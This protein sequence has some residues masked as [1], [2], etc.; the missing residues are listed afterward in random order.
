MK[1]IW[2]ALQRLQMNLKAIARVFAQDQELWFQTF[3]QIIALTMVYLI[4]AV[5]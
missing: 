3:V 4:I 5:V 1:N 2:D